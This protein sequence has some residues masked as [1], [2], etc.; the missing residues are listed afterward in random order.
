MLEIILI[1]YLEYRKESVLHKRS[2]IDDREKI[3]NCEVVE[4]MR[5]G[6]CLIHALIQ[7]H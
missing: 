4:P 7:Y 6:P 5:D 1:S 3:V 2:Y